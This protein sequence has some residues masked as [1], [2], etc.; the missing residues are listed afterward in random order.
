[1]AS[2][3]MCMCAFIPRRSASALEDGSAGACGL[4]PES[5][6]S[7]KVMA[8]PWRWA[9]PVRPTLPQLRLPQLDP[10]IDIDFVKDDAPFSSYM[11]HPL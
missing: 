9:L 11:Q 7:K 1:M 6:S 10:I 3:F 4:V 5:F 2:I 8:S